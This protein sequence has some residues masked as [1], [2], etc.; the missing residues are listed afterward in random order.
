MEEGHLNR[1]VKATARVR[2]GN[3]AECGSLGSQ[4]GSIK[5][6]EYCREVDR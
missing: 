1:R 4:V 3:A 2:R 5:W 6:S